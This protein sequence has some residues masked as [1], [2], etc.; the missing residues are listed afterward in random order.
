[1]CAATRT[2]GEQIAKLK[3]EKETIERSVPTTMVMADMPTPRE[4][5]ILMR[6]QYDKHGETVT[7][8][9][10]ETLAPFPAGAPHNRLGLAQWLVSP[11]QPLTSRVI[12]NRYWQSF[13]GTG[14]VKTV[15]DLGTQGDEPTHPELLDWLAVQFMEGDANTAGSPGPSTG[16]GHGPSTGSGHG[17]KPWDI[18]AMIKLMVTCST[19]RQSSAEAAEL[20]ARDP[21]NRLLARGARLRLPA[22]FIRDQALAVS[23]LLNDEIGGRSVSPYQPAGLWEELMSRNDG[24]NFTAQ[25]Y[26][27]DHGKNLYRR[28][29]YTFWKRTSPPP[30]LSTFDAPGREFCT[31]RRSRFPTRR[32]RRWC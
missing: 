28:T 25:V 27:Q 16:S 17:F 24:A 2:L 14:I 7:A 10:P 18:K 21:E 22:E 15:E 30:T 31:V 29:M 19:Y 6:G 32:S 8:D 20:L 5:F 1:M 11:Q 9:V 26:V 4:T 12:V 3:A 13:F 23:G